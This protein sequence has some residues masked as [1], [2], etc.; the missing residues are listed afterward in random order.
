[1]NTDAIPQENFT[2][3]VEIVADASAWQIGCQAKN[4][5]RLAMGQLEGWCSYEKAS[6]MMD[7]VAMTDAQTIVEIGVF[8]GKSLIPMAIAAQEKGSGLCYGVDPWSSQESVAGMEGVNA[9]WWGHVDHDRIFRHLQSKIDQFNLQEH[10][11]LIR[12]TSENAPDI[13]DIDLLHIDG[14][15]SEKTS[16]IDVTKWVPLVKKGGVIVFDDMTW[17]TQAK[18]VQWLDDHCIKIAEYSGD[19]VWGIWL[20]P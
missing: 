19:N 13:A 6:I 1:M 5:A 7:I 9:E 2:P 20:K 15:H 18:A 12:E 8:G 10:I 4:K 11:V 14:N 16:M 17:S 3:P